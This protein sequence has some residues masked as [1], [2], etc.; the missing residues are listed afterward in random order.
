MNR[1]RNR[2]IFVFLLATLAPLGLTLWTGLDLLKYSL[3]APLLDLNALSGA[4]QATGRELYQ[5]SQEALERDAEEGRATPAHLQPAEAQ[6]F[7]DSGEP[8]QFELSGD[9]E[10]Q[11]DY[12]VRGNGE[13]LRYS[14]P[15]GV[16]MRDLRDQI[17]RAGRVQE[18]DF[19]RGFSRTLLAVAAVVWLMALGA[20]VFL[21]ARI[22]RPVQQ[23]DRGTGLAS[24]PA[25][26]APACLPAEA[27]KSGP[28]SKRSI[29]WRASFSRR[30]SA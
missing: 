24:R 21:A 22:S 4:L 8:R 5:Q 12:Y 27:M 17:A 29:T 26:S 1:L 10:D 30:A 15:M 16:K 7:W 19:R 28:R 14:R 18:S 20:L 11:L 9:G 23:A 3:S 13:V 2:L 6:A 25:T